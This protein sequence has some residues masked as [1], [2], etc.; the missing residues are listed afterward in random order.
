MKKN[1]FYFKS[2]CALEFNKVMQRVAQY[3]I[4][5]ANRIRIAE[6]LPEYTTIL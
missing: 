6:L 3:A 5:P 1:F 4:C 2:A